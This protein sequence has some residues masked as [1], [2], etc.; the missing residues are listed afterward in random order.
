[1]FSQLEVGLRAH[2]TAGNFDEDR[3]KMPLSLSFRYMA[4][5]HAGFI[6]WWVENGMPFSAEQAAIYLLDLHFHGASWAIGIDNSN[7]S[8]V[9]PIA[10]G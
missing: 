6:R 5:A 2:F 9:A 8:S 10:E 4:A 1:M 7:Q 3:A